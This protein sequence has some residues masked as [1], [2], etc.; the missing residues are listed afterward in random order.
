M[1]GVGILVNA[2]NTTSSTKLVVDS[3]EVD[4]FDTELTQHGGAHDARLDGNVES[5]LSDERSIDSRGRVKLLA[6]GVDVA[7]LGINITPVLFRPGSGKSWLIV[8]LLSI[9]SWGI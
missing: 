2:E 6:I 4:L 7:V 9:C 3:A 1:S 8:N 5:T